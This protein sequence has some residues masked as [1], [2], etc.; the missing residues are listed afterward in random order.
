MRIALCAKMRSGKDTVAD[1]LVDEHNYVEFKLS[2]G[3]S[4]VVKMLDL[5]KNAG[6]N[7]SLYQGIG[8]Y[9]RTFDKDVWCNR[10]WR[11]IDRFNK[12]VLAT[13]PEAHTD[14]IV[15]SDI[16]QQ[17]EVDFF[18]EKGFVI[19]KID[20]SDENRYERVIESGDI[21]SEEDFYHETE[22][23]VDEIVADYTITNDGTLDDLRDE[24]VKLIEWVDTLER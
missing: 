24:V 16:R 7:R 21:M 1:L 20:S 17:N 5:D 10:T 12:L 2:R 22:K 15:V 9:M 8:Q 19:V 18:R 13:F 14:N 6:K 23:S 4:D 11:D 3:I